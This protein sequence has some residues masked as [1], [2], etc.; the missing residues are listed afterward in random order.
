[1]KRQPSVHDVSWFLDMKRTDQLD[2]DPPYQRK[3]VWT[4]K[5]R[6]YFL[7]TIF[8]NYPCPPIFI[9]KTIDDNG[10]SRYHIVDGKQRL[11][12]II[13]FSENKLSIDKDFGDSRLDGKKFNELD[14][15]EK[16]LFW[17]YSIPVDYIIDLADNTDINQIFD[18]VNRNSRNLQRQELRHA[19]FDGWFIS[20]VE[21][22]I[23]NDSIW[24]ELK[25]STKSNSKRMR[26]IQFI[27]ELFLI[28]IDKKIV[29]FDQDYIDERYGKL[30][31]IE[32]TNLDIDEYNTR[33]NE[34]K[35]Y[36]RL[37][38][39]NNSAVTKYAKTSNNIYV[40]WAL[41]ALG[42]YPSNLTADK[43]S[44]KYIEF[45]KLVSDFSDSD[46]PD[47]LL[48]TQSDKYNDAYAYYKNSR[49]ASTDLAQREERLNVLEKVMNN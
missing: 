21:K 13:L 40:L 7:D 31:S 15:E 28:L 20:E 8:R 47:D 1:M 4:T 12:T 49:G 30:D 10:S 2:L 16:K 14:T 46:K 29:G 45:M 9:H 23:E 18:R 42:K 6:K 32:E 48:N 35:K 26:D 34:V 38:E 22:E 33:K 17:N 24:D 11:E 27:S 44:K 3:S 36:L 39:S 19:K 41:I 25:I 5:D 37:I 43:F